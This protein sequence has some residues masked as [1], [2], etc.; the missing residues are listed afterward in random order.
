[1]SRQALLSLLFV[2]VAAALTWWFAVE[3]SRVEAEHSPGVSSPT[4]GP[5]GLSIG[6]SEAAGVKSIPVKAVRA[7]PARATSPQ[8]DIP[9]FQQPTTSSELSLLRLRYM[10]MPGYHAAVDIAYEDETRDEAW[11][12]A[13]ESAF[14]AT[15]AAHPGMRIVE[16]NCR[17]SL[18]RFRIELG[19]PLEPGPADQ[20]WGAHLMKSI[21]GTQH[22]GE[23][24][25]W[26]T[27]EPRT[28]V[29]YFFSLRVPSPYAERLHALLH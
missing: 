24:D 15:V 4:L 2:T 21:K 3:T 19:K 27:G 6:Q 18:C 25:F 7:D 12:T 28:R 29:V 13:I 1:M 16:G 17:E 23:I 26:A 8:A 20:E 22:E 10:R 14:V 11:A 9:P 5:A